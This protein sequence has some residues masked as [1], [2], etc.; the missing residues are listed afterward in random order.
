MQN[1]RRIPPENLPPRNPY[2]KSGQW[3]E[4]CTHKRSSG[5]PES[6]RRRAAKTETN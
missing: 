3:K 1:P 2:V 5:H 4:A 6:P